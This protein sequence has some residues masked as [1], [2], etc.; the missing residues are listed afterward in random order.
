M[1]DIIHRVGIRNTPGNVFKALVTI[2]GLSHWWVVGTKGNIKQRGI[3]DFGFTKMKVVMKKTNKLVMWECIKGPKEWIGTTITFQL[4]PKK[5]QTFVLFRHAGWKE[6]VEFMY[7]C[8]TKWAT[9]LISLKDWLE[10]G[11]GRPSPYDLK[12]HAG[13]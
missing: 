2:D 6:P 1:A 11:A 10:S 3:I 7:H 4:K 8:S 13:D 5:D 12:I 9:F